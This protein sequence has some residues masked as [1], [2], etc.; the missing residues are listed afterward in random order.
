MQLYEFQ[1]RKPNPKTGFGSFQTPQKNGFGQ[2]AG[3]GNP[4]L[5]AFTQ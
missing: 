3:F 2:G 4:N 1:T 5:I